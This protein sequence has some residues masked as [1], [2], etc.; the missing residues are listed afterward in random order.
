MPA[1][2]AQQAGVEIRNAYWYLQGSVK[3]TPQYLSGRNAERLQ[4]TSGKECR[5][6][7]GG[8]D[9]ATMPALRRGFNKLMGER[10]ETA[11]EAATH[12]SCDKCRNLQKHGSQRLPLHGNLR[13]HVPVNRHQ[14]SDLQLRQPK[15]NFGTCVS[16]YV[17]LMQTANRIQ[18]SVIKTTTEIE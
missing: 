1:H 10:E 13:Q 16:R 17:W 2:G 18:S 8:R 5:W 15:N 6:K 9:P 7:S 4:L 11:N 14:M 12:N 3:C